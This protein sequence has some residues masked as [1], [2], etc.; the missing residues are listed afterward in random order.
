[1]IKIREIDPEQAMVIKNHLPELMVMARTKH[2]NV[3]MERNTDIT[4]C[5]HST[6]WVESCTVTE[7]GEYIHAMLWYNINM[8]THAVTLKI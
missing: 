7:M 8:D 4:L 6:T 1:M 5:G 3:L 2:A